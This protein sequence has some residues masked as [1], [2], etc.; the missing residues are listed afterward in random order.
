MA[1][2]GN[3]RRILGDNIKAGPGL[4]DAGPVPAEYRRTFTRRRDRPLPPGT[5]Q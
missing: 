3:R 4:T 2:R 5:P 1:R